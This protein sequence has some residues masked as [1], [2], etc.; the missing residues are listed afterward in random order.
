MRKER[1]NPFRS[2]LLIEPAWRR[3][4]L[5]AVSVAAYA[6]AFLPLYAETGVGVSALALFPVVI[7][8]WLFG[9]WGGLL[10]GLLAMPA[11]ALLLAAVGEPGWRMVAGAGGLEGSALVVV[12]G[13]VIGL[14]RDLGLRLDHPLIA[15]ASPLNHPGIHLLH[16]Q[17]DI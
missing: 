6:G 14:L 10:A 11:N 17:Q 12:V 15:S 8:G 5:G 3:W 1:R 9:S 2:S 16:R 7:L 13:A 4:G